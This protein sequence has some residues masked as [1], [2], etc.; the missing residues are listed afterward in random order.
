MKWWEKLGTHPGLNLAA[1]AVTLISTLLAAYFYFAAL[2]KRELCVYIHPKRSTIL[3]A[4]QV[5]DLRVLWKDREITN[6]LSVVQIQ[7]WNHG[8]R[9]I[10]G[11]EM[12][13]PFAVHL[14]VP[15]TGEVTFRG[16]T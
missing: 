14:S 3:K 4:G 5:T 10:R 9:A 15:L 2:E 1:F 16:M 13:Q 6:D 8:K 11:G 7:V 12:L